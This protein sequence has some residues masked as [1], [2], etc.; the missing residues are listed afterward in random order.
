MNIENLLF[1]TKDGTPLNLSYNGKYWEGIICFKPTS[2]EHYSVETIRIVE[3]TV[4]DDEETLIY[5]KS[6]DDI[7]EFLTLYWDSNN[8]FVDE[9]A[10]FKFDEE[11][12]FITDTSALKF[13]YQDGPDISD[14]LSTN[15]QEWFLRLDGGP[16]SSESEFEESESETIY[17]NTDTLD[18]HIMFSADERYLSRTFQRTLYIDVINLDNRRTKLAE[19]RLFGE[20]VF[21]DERL[22]VLCSNLGYDFTKYDVLMLKDSDINEPTYDRQLVNLKR[23]ELLLE[24]PEIFSHIGSYSSLIDIIKFYGYDMRILE[25]WYNVNNG[26]FIQ[27]EYL[28]N[29]ELPSQD[30]LKSD[31]ISLAYDIS[32]ATNELDNDGLPLVREVFDYSIETANFKLSLLKK[33][34]NNAFMPVSSRIID[35]IGE[36]ISFSKSNMWNIIQ[37]N[38]F[39][40]ITAGEAN[41]EIKCLSTDVFITS[42][43]K[44]DKYL[45]QESYTPVEESDKFIEY[46]SNHDSIDNES[47]EDSESSESEDTKISAKCV[48]E[49]VIPDKDIITIGDSNITIED[50]D[51][52]ITLGNSDY[53]QKYQSLKW[54]ITHEDYNDDEIIIEGSYEDVNKV[55]LRLRHTGIYHANCIFTDIYNNISTTNTLDINVRPLQIELQGFYYDARQNPNASLY[56][57]EQKKDLVYMVNDIKNYIYNNLEDSENPDWKK[58]YSSYFFSN[59][60]TLKFTTTANIDYLV[61]EHCDNIEDVIPHFN[62]LRYIYNGVTVR[63]YTWIVLSSNLSRIAGVKSYRWTVYKGSNVD[64]STDNQFFVHMFKDEDEYSV[65]LTVTDINGNEYTKISK[66]IKVRKRAGQESV[67]NNVFLK[68]FEIIGNNVFKF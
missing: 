11:Q 18:I 10:L 49:F 14:I 9:F 19:I 46:D 31:Y 21:E 52:S 35:I 47:F 2:V 7:H 58:I 53:V 15:D 62:R 6:S 39:E 36:A 66:C 55:L 50:F 20:A 27:T 34:L 60:K 37:Q 51:D 17:V 61:S 3:K 33:K 67:L 38:R 48:L 30:Y 56:T 26:K 43:N 68:K 59:L 32:K 22:E 40:E 29:I 12:Q 54:V 44:F 24:G 57:Y 64:Y 28:K 25:H 42:D 23:K 65:S 5:P 41:A 8:T 63:P 16:E 4:I 45:G 1:F 13:T